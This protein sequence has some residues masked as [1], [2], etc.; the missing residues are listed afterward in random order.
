VGYNVCR[1]KGV[2][3]VFKELLPQNTD[4][5][6]VLDTILISIGGLGGI[7]GLIT[8]RWKTKYQ[9]KIQ[10]EMQAKADELSQTLSEKITRRCKAFELQIKKEYEFYDKYG[11][12]SL[13]LL[14]TISLVTYGFI[15]QLNKDETLKIFSKID[16]EMKR[17]QNLIMEYFYGIPEPVSDKCNLLCSSLERYH[18]KIKE[19]AI[20]FE[21]EPLENLSGNMIELVI[22]TDDINGKMV[23]VGQAI[24][25]RVIN[26]IEYP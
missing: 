14:D 18:T 12:Y 11:T 13:S 4:L 23:D 24:K 5:G 8:Y 16:Y 1:W 21:T 2:T 3:N 22:I 10:A 6:M 19:T 17:F 25:N 15:K 9:A 20:E 7:A 26:S